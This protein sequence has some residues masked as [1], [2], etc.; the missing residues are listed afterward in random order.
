MYIEPCITRKYV[1]VLDISVTALKGLGPSVDIEPL[2]EAILKAFSVQIKGEIPH[3]EIPIA[4]LSKV[5]PTLVNSLM[6]FQR[7][8]VK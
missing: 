2:P 3:R 7:Q 1:K 8:G 5:E 4:D 6:S